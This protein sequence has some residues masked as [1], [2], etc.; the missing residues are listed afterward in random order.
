MGCLDRGWSAGDW[1]DEFGPVIAHGVHRTGHLS[2]WQQRL[3]GRGQKLEGSKFGWAVSVP[4][5]RVLGCCRWSAVGGEQ[6]ECVGLVFVGGQA[7]AAGG[8]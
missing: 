5:G 7:V 3:R 2:R 1:L 4:A 8:F 6:V